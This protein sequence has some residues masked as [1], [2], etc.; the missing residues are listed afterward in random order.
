MGLNM[1][2]MMITLFVMFMNTTVFA[3]WSGPAEVFSGNWGNSAGQFAIE[4]GDSGDIFPKRFCLKQ[5]RFH[6]SSR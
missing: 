1:R 4:Y 3:G 5:W 2:L 6:R